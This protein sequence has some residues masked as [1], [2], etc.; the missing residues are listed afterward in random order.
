MTNLK[1]PGCHHALF[2]AQVGKKMIVATLRSA[3]HLSRIGYRSFN[4]IQ[5]ISA[6]SADERRYD[7]L[8]AR[9]GASVA[10]HP[11]Y[12]KLLSYVLLFSADFT[13]GITGKERASVEAVQDTI[14]NMLRRFIFSQYTRR[15]A[16]TL[17]ANIVACVSDLREL[18]QIKQNRLLAAKAVEQP[19]S[20]YKV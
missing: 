7:R 16:V 15:S 5:Q 11:H 19:G 14:L 12:V 6:D 1:I 17:F 18:V 4:S 10:A 20:S 13:N 3:G 2:I 8:L 9:V